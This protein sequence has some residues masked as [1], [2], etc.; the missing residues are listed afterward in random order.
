[1][2][3][4]CDV[5]RGFAAVTSDFGELAGLDPSLPVDA[6]DFVLKQFDAVHPVLDM[7]ASGEQ[8]RRVPGANRAGDVACGGVHG[9]VATG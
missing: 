1:M 6:F 3:L 7:V 5:A 9:I 2:V 8:A 4:N